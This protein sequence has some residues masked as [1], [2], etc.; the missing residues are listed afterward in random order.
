MEII[1]TWPM[2]ASGNFLYNSL[3][4]SSKYDLWLLWPISFTIPYRNHWNI[5]YEC[6]L[7]FPL[8]FQIQIIE[9]W[10]TTARGNPFQYRRHMTY[11]CLGHFLYSFLSKSSKHDIG[12]LGAIA[13]PIPYQNH[14]NMTCDCWG[15]FLYNSLSKS[16]KYD[17][18]AI[19]FTIPYQ[20]HWTCSYDC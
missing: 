17:L 3:S 15:H 14:R 18:C 9:I 16:T 5:T 12:M 7:Q 20:N 10:Y 6:W 4:R 1:E 8:Q 11:D 2:N 13:F 19:S